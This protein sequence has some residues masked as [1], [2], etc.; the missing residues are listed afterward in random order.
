[1]LDNFKKVELKGFRY[2]QEEADNAIYKE[3]LINNKCIVKMF[4]GTGKSLLM[5]KCKYLQN[6]KLVVYVFPSLSLI[7]QF[8]SDYFDKTN[9]LLLYYSCRS[10]KYRLYLNYSYLNNIHCF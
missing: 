3:L 5:R 4:C 2:Y 7:D 10:N 1:M 8:C 6:Q 9:C